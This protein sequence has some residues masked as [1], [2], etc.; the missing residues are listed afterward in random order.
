MHGDTVYFTGSGLAGNDFAGQTTGA[1]AAPLAGGRPRRLTD[2]QTVH[3]ERS[4]GDLL[5][6]GNAVLAPVADRGSVSLR[7]IPVA[8]SDVPL[9]ALPAVIG[10][11][12]VVK[13]FSATGRTVAAVVAD[14][15]G[16]GDIVIAEIASDG[17]PTRAERVVTDVSAP[18]REAGTAT[19]T[20]IAGAY[21]DGYPVHGFL[22]LPPGP[23]PHPVLLAVHGGPYAAYTWAVFDEAQMYATDGYAVVLPNPRGSSGYGLAHGRAIV[24]RPG[25]LDADDV[26]ALLAAALGRP[27]V[28]PARV[29]VDARDT[30]GSASRRSS[31]GGI[32]T[33]R[34]AEG[35]AAHGFRASG[36]GRVP[37]APTTPP[38]RRQIRA[39]MAW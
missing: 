25:T 29:G 20:E 4:A 13:A 9:A 1:W 37:P 3:I 6:V 16:T 10:G 23:G 30:G 12:R 35:E 31:D 14:A 8:G 24:G 33:C 19:V 5:V 36:G 26:L 15:A 21:P 7:A 11:Q 32:D 18:L 2:P 34:C 22:V 39:L 28:D 17:Q 38:V 27:E